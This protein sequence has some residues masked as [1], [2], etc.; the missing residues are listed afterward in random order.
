LTLASVLLALSMVY[1]NHDRLE[2]ALK[3]E[4]GAPGAT[5]PASPSPETLALETANPRYD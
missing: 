5:D 3:A 1:C 2:G 4:R